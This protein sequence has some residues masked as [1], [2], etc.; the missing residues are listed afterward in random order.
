M[1]NEGLSCRSCKYAAEKIESA[2]CK[3]CNYVSATDTFSNW[4]RP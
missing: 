3:Y 4:T 2:T 1:H